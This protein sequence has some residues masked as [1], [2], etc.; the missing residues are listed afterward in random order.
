MSISAAG[1]VSRSKAHSV[2]KAAWGRTTVGIA[3][4][5]LIPS[6][7]D[8][9]AAP[10]STPQELPP[11]RI[12]APQRQAA[13]P[14]PAPRGAA[15]A[16]RPRAVAAAA[17]RGA[18][19]PP[20]IGDGA[21]IRGYL[22]PSQAGVSRYTAPL[23]NTPQTVNVV[24]QQLM[25]DQRTTSVTDALRNVPGITFT[26]G[27]GGVQGD[28]INIRGYTAR[29]DIYRDGIRDPG[30]YARDAF[31]V[32][33]VEVYKGPSSFAFGRG[34]TGGVVNIVS[35][36]PQ[37]RDFYTVEAT[38]TS[39]NGKRVVTDFNKSFGD[40]AARLAMVG[41]DTDVAGRDAAHI[42]RYGFAPSVAWQVTDQTK[43]TISYVYQNDDNIADRGIPMLPGS[44]F[45]TTYRQP[46]PVP[47]NTYYGVLTPGQDDVEQ[48][49]AH[50]LINKF[51]H[52]FAPGLKLTNTTGYSNVERFNRTR[53]VQISGLGTVNSNLMSADVAPINN[54]PANRFNVAGNANPLT[55]A[56][57]L[58]NVWIA[59]TN[60]FQNQTNNQLISNVTDVN[61][62]FATGWLQHNVLVGMEWSREDREQFR[63]TFADNYRINVANPNPYAVGTL[64]PTT[65]AT[66]SDANTRGFYAQD[67]MK[68]TEWLELLGGVRYDVFKANADTYSFN[69]LT[70]GAASPAVTP[71]SLSSNTDFLSYRAGVVLHPTAYSSVYYMRG[72]SANPPAEFTT[73]TNGQQSLAPVESEVD[74]IG[75]KADLLNNRLNVN[76][77]IFRIKKKNDYE[78]Q[79]TTTAPIYVAI[80]T[81][82]VEGFEIGATGKLTDQWSVSG[83]YAYLKSQLV[84]SLTTANIG[85]QLAM[86]PRNSFSVFT[87]YD[88]DRQWSIG[89]GA[90]YVDSRFTSVTNDAR[91]PDY[92][93]FDAMAAYKV[94]RNLTLQFNIYNI[95]DEYYF[96]SAAGAG[97][98]IPGQ[99]RYVSLSGRASF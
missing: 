95:A 58:S 54:N 15:T 51:E 81:S 19:A 88:L 49:Q 90:F 65:A 40:V 55:G 27:E 22:P 43:N 63:T 1:A 4:A 97:Y 93:R 86:T 74:E 44:Y 84:E 82:Q 17:P 71:T 91:I 28:N 78:N 30:W 42:K 77:A 7:A 68:V 8:A 98:A 46:A 3:S 87:T 20:V 26:A 72:T 89:G 64:N 6:S 94:D 35:K 2:S 50:N 53:P 18:V 92:W 29:N 75:A 21:G 62:K 70:G 79:G 13:K 96:D 37:D 61:A 80:G 32:D 56:T 59:N 14:R 52:E 45:G 57:A 69:R 38:G 36:L 48:T 25:Q 10:P 99:G 83:G 66:V 67:Q 23:L 11:V 5:M 41:Y 9:Q 73:I 39:A 24:S 16:A 85:H 12:T 33:R 31:S 60:H 76:A 47:R 34:S